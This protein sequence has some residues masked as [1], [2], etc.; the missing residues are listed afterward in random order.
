MTDL[1]TFSHYLFLHPL[2]TTM[3]QLNLNH[4][5][6]LTIPANILSILTFLLG[7]LLSCLTF[8]TLTRTAILEIETTKVDLERTRSQLHSV[9]DCCSSEV[10]LAPLS[11]LDREGVLDGMVRDLVKIVD[12]LDKELED[13]EMGEAGERGEKEEGGENGWCWGRQ[14][15]EKRLRWVWMRKEIKRRMIRVSALKL[16]IIVAEISLL[17][18]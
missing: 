12:G 9:I 7:L 3:T 14:E 2:I 17:L 15:T 5:T 16:E 4:D 11:E 6:P 10:C 18:K 1:P 8:Y 13:F